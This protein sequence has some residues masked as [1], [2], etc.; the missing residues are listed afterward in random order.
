MPCSQNIFEGKEKMPLI[1]CG[2]EGFI[3]YTGSLYVGVLQAFLLYVV[4]GHYRT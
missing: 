1:H 4:E 3:Y 2:H